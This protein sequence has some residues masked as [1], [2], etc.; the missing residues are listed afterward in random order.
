MLEL[1]KLEKEYSDESFWGKVTKAFKKAGYEV[2]EKALWLYYAAQ[3]PNTPLWAKST[4][5]GALG[6]FISP[7]DAVPDFAPVVGYSDDLSVLAAAIAL[8]AMYVTEDV[9]VQA[10]QKL[11]TWF[12]S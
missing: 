8:V 11:N 1:S 4:I 6:Y 5:Y 9:K 10:K 3:N 12:G 7:I 2:I